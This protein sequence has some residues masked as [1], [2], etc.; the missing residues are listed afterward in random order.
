MKNLRPKKKPEL[1]NLDESQFS[2]P[3]GKVMFDHIIELYR[4]VGRLEGTQRVELALVMAALGAIISVAV[5]V[6]GG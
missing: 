1:P 2:S 3:G 5:K 4:A 6:W